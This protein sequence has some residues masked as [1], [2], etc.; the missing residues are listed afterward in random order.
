MTR[1]Y[2]IPRIPDE[3]EL[4]LT[5]DERQ[6]IMDQFYNAELGEA[7]QVQGTPSDEPNAIRTLWT[8][9]EAGPANPE[10]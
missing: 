7:F 9:A 6:R 10:E 5:P 8:Q 4:P 1:C 3:A 2:R